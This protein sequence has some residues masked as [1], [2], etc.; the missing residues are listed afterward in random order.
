MYA[1]HNNCVQS[2]LQACHPLAQ[3]TQAPLW[4]QTQSGAAHTHLQEAH[5]LAAVLWV[6]LIL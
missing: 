6:L 2:V 4:W 3:P 1:T 5:V